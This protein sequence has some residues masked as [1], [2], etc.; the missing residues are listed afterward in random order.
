M[1]AVTLSTGGA[2]NPSFFSRSGW[3]VSA[4]VTSFA[5]VNVDDVISAISCLHDKSS[6]ADPLPVSVMKQAADQIRSKFLTELFNR[7]VSAGQF[8]STFKDAFITP[9]G[10]PRAFSHIAQF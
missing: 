5:P 9:L 8:P 7:S 10:L 4:S 3:D 6:T 2:P 1:N